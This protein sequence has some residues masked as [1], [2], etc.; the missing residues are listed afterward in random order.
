MSNSSG[1]IKQVLIV[2]GGTAGW[3]TACHLAKQLHSKNPTAVQVTLLESPDIPTIGVGEGTVPMMRQTLQHFG[4]RETD[5]IRQCD[6]TFKQSILFQNWMKPDSAGQMHRYHH[7]FDYPDTD[8]FDLTPY[9]LLDP[10]NRDYVNAVSAQGMVC[11]A[12]LAPKLITHPE[13]AGATNYAYHLDAGKF[14]ALL[15]KHATEQ[16][17]VKHLLANAQHIEL[18]GN[19]DI[20][21]I[22]TDRLGTL[23][24]DLYIDC[25]GFAS[26]L[27]G[28]ALQVPFHAKNDVLFVD[29][30]LAVQVPYKDPAQPIPSY[31]IAT[32]QPA[33]WIWDIGL[34][35]RRGAGYVY[36]S[37]YTTHTEAEQ[38]LRTY[39]GAAGEDLDV[40]RIPMN[41]GYRERFWQGNC[42]AIG[43][44]QG[45]VE[46][47]EATG[48]LMYDVTARMLAEQ[49]PAHRNS[50]PRL[51][52]QFN[53]R[54]RYGWERVIEFIKLHYCLSDRDDSAFW[55]D[56][57]SQGIPQT[58]ADKLALW[59]LQLPS[60]YDFASRYEVFNLEN[61]L[62]VLYGMQYPTQLELS[63]S[64]Y[65]QQDKAKQAFSTIQSMQQQLLHNLQPNRAVL[66]RIQQHGLQ[67]V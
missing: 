11:D 26:L 29:H 6:A 24:A 9:W 38:G 4:I 42:V 22:Q 1:M 57:R 49:F 47:L 52:T 21:A 31:T 65:E 8:E 61:Y 17:G 20:T 12:G 40:R 7:A 66:E 48:L 28:Q 46:P 36:S 50:M 45:F 56:N 59:Q 27:L 51:A 13:Y 25:S 32:A 19:G 62:Y 14:A 58:L 33:G 2:G 10:Q 3:L 55:R 15:T 34:S 23:T 53:Q 44:S 41:V 5:F 30:A 67:R 18:A 64:R 16:L 37:A 43:L 35:K 54:V 63:R 60:H 39:L